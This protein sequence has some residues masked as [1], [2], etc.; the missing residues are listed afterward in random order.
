VLQSGDRREH[1][2]PL[3]GQAQPT[4]PQPFGERRRADVLVRVPVSHLA[5]LI[6]AC[7][8]LSS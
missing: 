5:R 1:L 4:G 2:F 8:R 3:R 6:L 7:G